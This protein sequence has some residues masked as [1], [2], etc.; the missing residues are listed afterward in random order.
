MKMILATLGKLSV[1]QALTAGSTDSTNVIQIPASDYVALADAWMSIFT[2]V[3]AGGAGALTFD[4]VMSQE[5]TLDT[6]VSVVRT[7]CSAVTD[8][9]VA[10]AGRFISRINVGKT[11]VE[12]LDTSGSDYAFIG[13]I[14]TLGGSA[15]I[16]IDAALSPSEPP[17]ESHRMV[18]VSPVGV[19]AVASVGSGT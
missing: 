5:S 11:L 2:V 10:T 9:R 4:L 6:N 18:T 3:A 8:V 19:P 7:Y 13:L 1:A 15:T 16:T 12:M 17:T 14:T